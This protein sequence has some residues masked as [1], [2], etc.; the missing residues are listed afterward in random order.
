MGCMMIRWDVRGIVS[1]STARY[2]FNT[3]IQ[4]RARASPLPLV[5]HGSWRILKS[6]LKALPLQFVNLTVEPEMHNVNGGPHVGKLDI[7][8]P[9]S[10]LL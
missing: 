10:I 8:P 9:S 4:D 3:S 1:C 7:L 6:H 2:T 5:P